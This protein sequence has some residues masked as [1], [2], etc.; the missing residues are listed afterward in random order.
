MGGSLT[1][2]KGGGQ[3]EAIL[4]GAEGVECDTD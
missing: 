1:M 4:S 3:V 2:D